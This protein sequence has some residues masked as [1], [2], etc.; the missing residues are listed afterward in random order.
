MKIGLFW[1]NSNEKLPAQFLLRG[2]QKQKSQTTK[3][4][5]SQVSYNCRLVFTFSA[6]IPSRIYLPLQSPCT[7]MAWSLHFNLDFILSCCSK[8]KLFNF[9]V[10]NLPLSQLTCAS[11]NVLVLC[12]D[13]IWTR[14]LNRNI[15][16]VI[17]QCFHNSLIFTQ[18]LLDGCV[19]TTER[20]AKTH[21]KGFGSWF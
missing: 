3:I 7:Y 10:R 5:P 11:F 8:R 13:R 17:C 1:D 21:K 2:T 12:E 20:T 9:Q 4:L 14:P 18:K 19:C 6:L 16:Y 15:M